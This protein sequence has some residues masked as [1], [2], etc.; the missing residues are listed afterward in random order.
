MQSRHVTR[1]VIARDERIERLN[2]ERELWRSGRLA[3]ERR[4]QAPPGQPRSTHLI[5]RLGER[6]E[7]VRKVQDYLEGKIWGQSRGRETTYS[8]A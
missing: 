8:L 1:Q 6:A 4:E 3:P 7:L 5:F 2:R